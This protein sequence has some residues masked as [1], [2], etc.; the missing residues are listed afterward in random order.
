M[1]K[2]ISNANSE[3]VQ[4]RIP[5]PMTKEIDRI[6]EKFPMYASRQQFI[7]TAIREKLEKVLRLEA[8]LQRATQQP[9]P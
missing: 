6:V 5:E 1:P 9:Q 8:G 4:I 7:E 3:R 2:K